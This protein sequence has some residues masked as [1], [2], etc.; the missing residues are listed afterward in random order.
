MLWVIFGHEHF[1]NLQ[2]ASN[3]LT[4]S[5]TLEKPY[6]L[7]VEAG[8]FAV[9][10]FFYVGGFMAAYVLLKEKFFSISNYPLLILNRL[11]RIWPS[12]LISILIFYSIFMH[13]GSGPN[14][15]LAENQ[16]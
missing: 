3:T 12:Y 9:D 16:V 14:W 13:L 10:T 11:L 2:N 6:F 4:F 7:F 15:D 1:F 5:S 8:M